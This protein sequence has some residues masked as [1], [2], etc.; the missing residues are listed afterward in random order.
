MDIDYQWIEDNSIIERLDLNELIQLGINDINSS[1]IDSKIVIES[2]TGSGKTNR[3]AEM[4]SKDTNHYGI[5]LTTSYAAANELYDKICSLNSDIG[6]ETLLFYSYRSDYQK[7]RNNPE[8]FNEFRWIIMNKDRLFAGDIDIF[9]VYSNCKSINLLGANISTYKPVVISDEAIIGSLDITLSRDTL[10]IFEL[11]SDLHITERNYKFNDIRYKLQLEID[12]LYTSIYNYY[13]CTLEER[14]VDDEDYK[15]VRKLW[16]LAKL[17]DPRFQISDDRNMTFLTSINLL[18]RVK[19]MYN[20]V[21]NNDDVF[22]SNVINGVRKDININVI[23]NLDIPLIIFSA[24]GDLEYSDTIVHHKKLM[25]F[26]PNLV[27]LHKLEFSL[28]DCYLDPQSA[29]DMLSYI[30]SNKFLDTIKDNSIIVTFMNYNGGSIQVDNVNVT[31]VSNEQFLYDKLINVDRKRGIYITHFGSTDLV[32]VNSLSNFSNIYFLNVPR[33]ANAVNNDYYMLSDG[34]IQ[35]NKDRYNK[36]GAAS[37]IQAIGRTAY[38]NNLVKVSNRIK[39]S[40]LPNIK[41]KEV[42]HVYLASDYWNQSKF[43]DNVL[44]Y[45]IDRMHPVKNIDTSLYMINN[46]EFINKQ[47]GVKVRQTYTSRISEVFKFIHETEDYNIN[48]VIEL[49]ASKSKNRKYDITR[50]LEISNSFN[51]VNE[52]A[53]M[54]KL[55]MELK[56]KYNI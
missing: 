11:F 54:K 12:K 47:S 53:V 16:N 24:T 31:P 27:E 8:L 28:P 5:I 42:T 55:T 1:K 41:D 46:H 52:D 18:Y 26:I 48:D 25:D 4:I 36:L 23:K 22:L 51:L 43:D 35:G 50:F 17:I 44:S 32:G 37:I 2:P 38:R 30:E 20:E 14:E 39:S 56:D 7:Y 15:Y 33:I 6:K 34:T 10:S 45:I 40:G 9:L 13:R 49:I 21:M 19:L 3:I 29:F